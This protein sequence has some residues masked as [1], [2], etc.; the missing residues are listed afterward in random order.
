[1]T[2]V[3]GIFPISIHFKKV[4]IVTATINAFTRKVNKTT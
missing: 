3:R 4:L 2:T 1:M